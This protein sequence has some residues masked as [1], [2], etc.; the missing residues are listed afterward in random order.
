MG[1]GHAISPAKLIWCP[2]VAGKYYIDCGFINSFS[3]D[4]DNLHSTIDCVNTFMKVDMRNMFRD[5]SSA[6]RTL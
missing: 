4:M 5:S 3:P 6:I 1:V 2:I